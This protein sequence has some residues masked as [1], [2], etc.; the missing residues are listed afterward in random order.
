LREG[1][2]LATAVGD[3]QRASQRAAYKALAC[4]IFLGEPE[5]VPLSVCHNLPSVDVLSNSD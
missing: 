3:N 5:M 2:S 1:S 4:L